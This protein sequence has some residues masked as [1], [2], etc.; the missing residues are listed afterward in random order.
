[1]AMGMERAFG[2]AKRGACCFLGLK[3][4]A[5]MGRAFGAG[6]VV[7]MSLPGVKTPGW[8]GAAGAKD[9]PPP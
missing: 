4:Q 1:M 2:A 9:S 5:G 6:A 8:D 7:G 3:P